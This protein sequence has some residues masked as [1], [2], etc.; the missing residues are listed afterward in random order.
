MVVHP[1]R[2]RSHMDLLAAHFEVVPAAAVSAV[3]D[4]PRAAITFD[5]GYADS[6]SAAARVLLELGLPATFFVTTDAIRNVTEFWWDRLAHVVGQAD[7]T[8]RM[9]LRVGRRTVRVSLVDEAA[10]RDTVLRLAQL[11]A[12]EQPAV[13]ERAIDDM[14]RMTGRTPAPCS[15]HRRLSAEEIRALSAE[16]SF[17]VGSHTCSHAALRKLSR[18][19]SVHELRASRRELADVL[20]E[21]PRLLAYPYGGPGTVARRNAAEARRTGYSAAF[22]NVRGPAD[23]AD[24]FAIPRIAVGDWD[25]ETLLSQLTQW[26]RR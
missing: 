9:A 12:I 21:S 15:V 2:F 17:E 24:P 22:V 23:G 26:R 6:V 1:D 7:P 25:R 16:P 11:L 5:D 14:V 4:R 18:Q 19:D 3:G 10:R 20:G 13:V 8:P